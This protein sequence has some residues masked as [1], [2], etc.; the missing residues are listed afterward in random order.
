M[1]LIRSFV[2]AASAACLLNSGILT[3]ALRLRLVKSTVGP[4]SIAQGAVVTPL[5]ARLTP[6]Y[7][8]LYQV[9]LIV[10]QRVPKGIV[11][12]TLALS[13]SV[14]NSVQIYVQ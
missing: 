11:N 1:G 10:P 6:I 8:G 9:N 3:A 2:L 4:V 7:A 14:S 13:E 5:Y 12:L